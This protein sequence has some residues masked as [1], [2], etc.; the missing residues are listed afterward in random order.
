MT[1]IGQMW[2]HITLTRFQQDILRS[3]QIIS[4]EVEG[5]TTIGDPDRTRD[6][7]V[8]IKVADFEEPISLRSMGE[9]MT[10][11][12]SVA[13]AL[14]NAQ[15]GVLVVDEIE[16]GLHYSVQLEMWK[17]IFATAH[18]LNVQVF[19]TT[20][21]WDCV[22]AFQQA[23]AESSGDDGMLIRLERKNS[24]ILVTLF[25][26]AKLAIATREQIEVR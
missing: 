17:L 4:P 6:R 7:I 23:S 12:F 18:R 9:G 8:I 1:Q 16:S 25:D 24:D 11:L 10:R 2:D 22:A 19:A 3:I 20:H 15:G 5:L 26:E 13:L 14:V 21:S